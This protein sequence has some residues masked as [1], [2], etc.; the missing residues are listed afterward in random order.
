[1][2]LFAAAPLL[3]QDLF[4]YVDAAIIGE[5]L[6]DH[7]IEQLLFTEHMQVKS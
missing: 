3:G 7:F 2:Q 4:N 1:M 5:E 6:L